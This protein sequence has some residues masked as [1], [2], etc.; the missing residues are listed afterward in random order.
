MGCAF[1]EDLTA[2]VDGELPAARA[3]EVEGHL[4]SCAS[5]RA[6]EG[7][8]RRTVAQLDA[9]P[10]PAF[11]PTPRLRRELME[12]LEEPDNVLVA[13]VKAWLR[14]R[15][16]VPSLGAMA[17]AALAVVMVAHGRNAPDASQLDVASDLDVVSNMDVLEDY[18][19]LGVDNPD[20]LDV[21]QNLKELEVSP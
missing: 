12:R 7:L 21:V 4:T 20:D 8:L 16:L 13:K 19:V 3:K 17:A 15:V 11:A 2:Y 6:T 14:P 10:A 5:C 9:L 1:E 18:D